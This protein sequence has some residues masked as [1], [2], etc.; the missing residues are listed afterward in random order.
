MSWK[1]GFYR[2]YYRVSR[3]AFVSEL[4]AFGGLGVLGG[5]R[6]LGLGGPLGG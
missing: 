4:R 2:G 6:V 1:L 3:P 5:F